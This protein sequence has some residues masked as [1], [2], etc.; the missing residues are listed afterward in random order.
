M[1]I[2][3]GGQSIACLE[4]RIAFDDLGGEP[5]NADLAFI[6]HR[7]STKIAVTI[8]AKADEPFGDTVADTWGAALERRIQNPASQ[9]VRRVEM[10]ASALIRPRSRDA[11]KVAQLRYQLL[12]AAAR[13]VAWMPRR[14]KGSLRMR[15]APT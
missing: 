15:I 12:T 2:E 10:L 8:E 6:G 7:D 4:H 14:E 11:P 5:R 3:R 1:R 9:G 13:H